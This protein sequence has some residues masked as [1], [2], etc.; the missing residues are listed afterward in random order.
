[1]PEYIAPYI[2]LPEYRCYCCG[3]LPPV[4]EEDVISEAYRELFEQ[5]AI[6]RNEWGQPIPITSGYRCP[7]HN[8]RIGGSS[9]SIHMFGLALDMG[10]LSIDSVSSV[11]EI[12]NDL[13]PD[14]RMGV[15]KDKGTFI[16]IDTG[17]FITPKASHKWRKRARWYD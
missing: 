1:V 4:F 9:L 12:V 3:L 7:E 13:C 17:Y 15:Y 8:K 14:L 2:T 5:F 11:A 10:F 16:H 6:I